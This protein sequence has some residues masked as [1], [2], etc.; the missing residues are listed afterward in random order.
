MKTAIA[1]LGLSVILTAALGFYAMLIVEVFRATIA[2]IVLTN[3]AIVIVSGMAIAIIEEKGR[4]NEDWI[5]AV[6]VAIISFGFTLIYLTN[7]ILT[8]I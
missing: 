5:I 4:K 8:N 6:G 1:T 7:I 2:E 3:T